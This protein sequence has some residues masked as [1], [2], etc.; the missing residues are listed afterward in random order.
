[1]RK[2][3]VGAILTYAGLRPIPSRLRDKHHIDPSTRQHD[4]D[5]DSYGHGGS[6]CGRRDSNPLRHHRRHRPPTMRSVS[7]QTH[8]SPSHHHTTNPRGRI[9]RLESL[10]GTWSNLPS[11]YSFRDWSSSGLLRNETKQGSQNSETSKSCWRFYSIDLG[12]FSRH[13]ACLLRSLG[14][15]RST[16]T[17]RS[18]SKPYHSHHNSM[19]HRQ[20]HHHWIPV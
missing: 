1:M 9:H 18:A 20:L 5:P 7:L 13:A 11:G 6:A 2:F 16:S 17:G 4:H 15:V 8:P 14:G 10:C 12:A 19:W 3:L